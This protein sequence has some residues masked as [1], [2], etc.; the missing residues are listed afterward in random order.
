MKT[1]KDLKYYLSLPYKIEIYF[2]HEDNTW[3]AVHPELG[4]GTCYAIGETQEEALKLLAE[5]KKDILEIAISEGKEIPEPIFEKEELPSGQFVLRIPRTLHAQLKSRADKEEV[6][7]NQYVLT[8]LSEHIGIEKSK[9]KFTE[10]VNF[11]I[12]AIPI[13]AG[14]WNSPRIS[15]SN[16][17]QEKYNWANFTEH[18]LGKLDDEEKPQHQAKIGWRTFSNPIQRTIK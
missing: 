10:V 1:N 8:I 16:A 15:Y 9:D 6:S 7:L 17:E 2:E 3:V 12:K 18:I 14:V 5:A 13:H 11:M 4:R